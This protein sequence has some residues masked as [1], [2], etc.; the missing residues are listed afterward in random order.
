MVVESMIECD[1]IAVEKQDRAYRRQEFL[2]ERH[3]CS[4]DVDA[5]GNGTVTVTRLF[6]Q[7]KTWPARMFGSRCVVFVGLC[8]GCGKWIVAR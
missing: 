4:R 1:V 7:R 3:E 2:S 6:L 8:E 5:D